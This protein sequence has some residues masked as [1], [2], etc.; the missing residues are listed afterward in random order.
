MTEEKKEPKMSRHTRQRIRIILECIDSLS[1]TANKI[2]SEEIS[3]LF[4]RAD[5]PMDTGYWRSSS[6]INVNPSSGMGGTSVV[7]AAAI[8]AMEGKKPRDILAEKVKLLERAIIDAEFAVR[9]IASI[10]DDINR[11]VVK[12]REIRKPDP[13]EACRI[14]NISKSGLCQACYQEWVNAGSPNRQLWVMYKNQ[15]TNSQ[16]EILIEE[17][18]AAQSDDSNP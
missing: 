3:E 1:R 14:V 9:R 6:F 16:G 13:C 8:A 5:I 18:P 17:P 2:N 15:T 7:E 10:I 11:P 12:Q 4:R